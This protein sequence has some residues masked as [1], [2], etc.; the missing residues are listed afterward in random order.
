MGIDHI[1]G[2]VNQSILN[3]RKGYSKELDDKKIIVMTGD[4]RKGYS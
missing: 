2:L 1:E 3:L 4:G